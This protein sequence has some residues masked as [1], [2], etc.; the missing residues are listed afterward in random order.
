MRQL[1]LQMDRLRRVVPVVF[2]V[3]HRK[4]A[5]G[6]FRLGISSS[7]PDQERHSTLLFRKGIYSRDVRDPILHS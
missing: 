7:R 6:L 1:V 4:L 5:S 2:S 3:V